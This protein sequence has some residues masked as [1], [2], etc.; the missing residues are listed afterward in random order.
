[1]FRL[2]GYTTEAVPNHE[3]IQET[4]VKI[5]DKP[6]SFKGS[7]KWIGSTEVAFVLETLLSVSSCI[8]NVPSGGEMNTVGIVL[9]EHFSTH[10]TPVMIGK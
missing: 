4:L 5:G 10:G 2:Q 6:S 3:K 7:T 1:M 9:L 8:V